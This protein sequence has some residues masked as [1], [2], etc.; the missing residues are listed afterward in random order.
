MFAWRF[1]N[2]SHK[3]SLSYFC[4]SGSNAMCE[5]YRPQLFAC[6]FSKCGQTSSITGRKVRPDRSAS[7][8]LSSMAIVCSSAAKTARM[9]RPGP[10]DSSVAAPGWRELQAS[11]PLH[12]KG[13]T[14]AGC[15]ACR[16]RPATIAYKLK[17]SRASQAGGWLLPLCRPCSDAVTPLGPVA[18]LLWFQS[19]GVDALTAASRYSGP[20][21]TIGSQPQVFLR[22]SALRGRHE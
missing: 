18:E 4:L 17:I 1:R 6:Y 19:M 5:R 21:R 3:K 12:P 22:E 10:A 8:V 16:Q 11:T 7:L 14:E 13:K 9:N 2:G 15:V 20:R